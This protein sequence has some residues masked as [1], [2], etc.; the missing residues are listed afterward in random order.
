MLMDT[1]RSEISKGHYTTQWQ[2]ILNYCSGHDPLLSYDISAQTEI[3][4]HLAE[5]YMGVQQGNSTLNLSEDPSSLLTDYYNLYHTAS[6]NNF[7]QSLQAADYSDQ[8][9]KIQIPSLLVWG[10][11]DFVVPP[12][13]GIDGLENLGSANKQLLLCPHSG[14]HPLATDTDLVEDAI[15]NFIKT[16]E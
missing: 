4:A 10:Q 6:G 3:Y 11:F 12:V 2:K 7:L 13:V 15:I 1:A 5:G 16:C 9:Y 14:H 8:L